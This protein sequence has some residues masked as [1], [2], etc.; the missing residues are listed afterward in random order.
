MSYLYYIAG[1]SSLL[2]I[3]TVTDHVTVGS[4]FGF[5][6]VPLLKHREDIK[7]TGSG[8]ILWRKK[9]LRDRYKKSFF[10]SSNENKWQLLEAL[11]SSEILK[12]SR[13]YR[14]EKYTL[15]ARDFPVLI[16]C[17]QDSGVQ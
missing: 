11:N 5:I 17:F 2:S 9:A 6:Q 3:T 12:C 10:L 8:Q 1:S 7:I 14:F 16:D 15:C 13:I 4:V